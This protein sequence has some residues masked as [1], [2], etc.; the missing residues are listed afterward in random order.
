MEDRV[1]GGRLHADQIVRA[2][3]VCIPVTETP[4]LLPT[5][6]LHVGQAHGRHVAVECDG[7]WF[8][9]VVVLPT[10]GVEAGVDGCVTAFAASLVRSFRG[11]V[12]LERED[13][14]GHAV[15]ETKLRLPAT[16]A[17]RTTGC[18]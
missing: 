11:D 17:R 5:G 4:E 14:P 6:Q 10:T 16:W 1:D 8:T 12:L 15:K 13:I 18:L 2:L 7:V 3:C 9:G